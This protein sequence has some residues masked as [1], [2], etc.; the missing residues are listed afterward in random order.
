MRKKVMTET[1]MQHYKKRFDGFGRRPSEN[2]PFLSNAIV[3][4]ISI[5]VGLIALCVV[6]LLAIN[7]S[8]AIP[9][10]RLQ[11]NVY[12]GT[13]LHASWWSP[14]ILSVIGVFFYILD[15]VLAYTLYNVRQRIAAYALLMGGLFAH[16][17]LLVAVISI[18]LNN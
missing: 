16:I 14:Y 1:I 11:Y 15:F 18:V 9:S 8:E 3:H 13:S 5:A 17:A 4:W 7:I 6:I 10:I 2:T 12:F